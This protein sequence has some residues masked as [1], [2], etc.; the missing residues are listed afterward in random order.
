MQFLP[1]GRIFAAFVVG[2][3]SSRTFNGQVTTAKHG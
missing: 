1:D 3:R 2:I